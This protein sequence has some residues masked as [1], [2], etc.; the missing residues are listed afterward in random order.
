MNVTFE[1]NMWEKKMGT[2]KTNKQKETFSFY[3]FFLKKTKKQ[4]RT[5]AQENKIDY[6]ESMEHFQFKEQTTEKQ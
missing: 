1:L 3:F 6:I 4:K 2:K 5:R